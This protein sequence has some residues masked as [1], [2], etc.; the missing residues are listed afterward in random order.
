MSVQ[1][2]DFRDESAENYEEIHDRNLKVVGG[3]SQFFYEY[4]LLLLH[5]YHGD[6]QPRT[7]LDFGCGRGRLTAMLTQTYPKATVT[8]FDVSEQSIHVARGQYGLATS[9]CTDI[10]HDSLY[11]LIVASGVFHHILPERQH[12]ELQHLSEHLAPG[13]VMVLFEHNP[14]NP[15]TQWIVRHEPFD[16]DS[17][18]ITPGQM[19]RLV[20]DA[21]LQLEGLRFTT[22]FPS[23]LKRLLPCDRLLSWCPLGGQYMVSIRRC[24]VDP[25]KRALFSRPP[26]TSIP[27]KEEMCATV[28]D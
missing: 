14:F 8:G 6:L 4:R 17:Y 5:R 3:N 16:F 28:R 7:I 24:I 11:D 12:T 26:Q 15:L 22:F 20:S 2:F 19:R 9:F 27:D 23:Y 13:G 1:D 21:G 18:L 10:A 25:Q